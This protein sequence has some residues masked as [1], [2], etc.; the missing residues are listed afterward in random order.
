MDWRSFNWGFFRSSPGEERLSIFFSL[1]TASDDIWERRTS[2][3]SFFRSSSLSFTLPLALGAPGKSA[4]LETVEP[5]PV[6]VASAVPVPETG[7]AA[8]AGETGAAFFGLAAAFA[9]FGAALVPAVVVGL[10]FGLGVESAVPAPAAG[11]EVSWAVAVIVPTVI[12]KKPASRAKEIGNILI[13][14]PAL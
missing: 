10:G 13:M 14:I 6:E 2:S 11:T 9:G 1:A 8:G 3:S 4:E 5:V 7:E 12:R